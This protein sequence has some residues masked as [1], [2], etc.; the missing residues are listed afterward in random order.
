MDKRKVVIITF[1][2]IVSL[3]FSTQMFMGD[4]EAADFFFN[5]DWIVS[6]DESY[7]NKSILLSADLLESY[8]EWL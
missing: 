5:D 2:M 7:N 4:V 1:A 3:F 8:L 6:S